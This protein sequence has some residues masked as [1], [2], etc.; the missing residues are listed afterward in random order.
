MTY[1]R[2]VCQVLLAKVANEIVISSLRLRTTNVNQLT[3]EEFFR[4]VTRELFC[5]PIPLS[6]S[7][8][9]KVSKC[10]LSQIWA[11]KIDQAGG[12]DKR[13]LKIFVLCDVRDP[14]KRDSIPY[15][16]LAVF[17]PLSIAPTLDK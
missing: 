7:D 3:E 11:C 1:S 10:C 12:G 5:D 8:S 15:N 6:L 17:I 14:V 13:Y 4:A 2:I 9:D 16:P